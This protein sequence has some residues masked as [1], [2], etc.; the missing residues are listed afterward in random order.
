MSGQTL[1]SLSQREDTKTRQLLFSDEQ[2]CQFITISE[3]EG[4]KEELKMKVE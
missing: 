1:T 4:R 2:V 3:I